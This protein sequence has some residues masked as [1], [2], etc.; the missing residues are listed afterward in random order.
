[1]QEAPAPTAA[2]EPAAG[3][4]PTAEAAVVSAAPAGESFP[5]DP[6][7][8]IARLSSYKGVG[9]TTA[10]ALIEALGAENVFPT[11]RDAPD[12]IREVLGGRRAERL[13]AAW[14]AE[15]SAAVARTAAAAAP[16]EAAETTVTVAEPAAAGE[17]AAPAGAR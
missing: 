1:R 10:E 12:R 17:A 9:R 15:A 14:Q 13:I 7:A 8:V 11:L 2:G 6:A 4:A 5:T 16:A 3:T